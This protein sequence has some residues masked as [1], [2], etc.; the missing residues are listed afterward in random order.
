MGTYWF[1][2]LGAAGLTILFAIAAVVCAFRARSRLESEIVNRE[3]GSLAAAVTVLPM[4]RAMSDEEAGHMVGMA[5]DLAVQANLLALNAA[6]EAARA[7]EQG[8]SLAAVAEEAQRLSEHVAQVSKEAATV[9]GKAQRSA[10]AVSLHS[11]HP[12]SPA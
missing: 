3:S 7:G 1:A 11:L 4:P 2:I 10:E 6:I 12:Q 8:G 5:R 9:I